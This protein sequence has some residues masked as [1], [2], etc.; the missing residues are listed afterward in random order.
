MY[1]LP[2]F[3]LVLASIG[4]PLNVFVRPCVYFCLVRL[5]WFTSS[6]SA[7]LLS[8]SGLGAGGR[9]AVEG[10]VLRECSSEAGTVSFGDPEQ[11]A[12]GLLLSSA[13]SLLF[14]STHIS[15]VGNCTDCL[16]YGPKPTAA[17]IEEV[18]F[19][20]GFVFLLQGYGLDD[21][22]AEQLSDLIGGLTQVLSFV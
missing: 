8:C 15:I 22:S 17:E 14:L 11:P 19:D 18:F 3:C 2:R 20:C 12:P 21:M 10:D 9:Q 13:N 1:S 5:S 7:C 6:L 4:W 16:G